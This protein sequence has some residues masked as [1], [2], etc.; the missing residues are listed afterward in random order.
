MRWRVLGLIIKTAETLK[1][2]AFSADA[3]WGRKWE[4]KKGRRRERK[5]EGGQEGGGE[6]REREKMREVGKR[7]KAGI[8]RVGAWLAGGRWGSGGVGRGKEGLGM[9]WA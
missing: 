8:G 2:L 9:H 1:S 7:V 6:G 5:K 3:K 4:G